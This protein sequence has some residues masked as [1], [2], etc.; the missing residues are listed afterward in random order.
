MAKATDLQIK[1]VTCA[2]EPIAFRTPLKFG[3][4]VQKTA[5]LVNVDV[6]VESRDGKHKGQ[7][8]GSMPLGNLWSWPSTVCTPDQTEAAMKLF[9]EEIVNLAQICT[10]AGHPIDLVYHLAGEYPHLAKTLAV[11]NKMPE[12]LPALAQLVAASALDAALHDAFGRM[13]Q[14]SS[15]DVLTK[16][17]MTFDLSEYLDKSF[18]GEYLDRYTLRIPAE[19]LA[20][21]HLVGAVDPL[22]AG[23]VAQKI[24]DGLPEY[25]GE[26]IVRDQLTHLKIKLRGNDP[27]WDRARILG[28]D[29]VATTTAQQTQWHYSLD[30]NEQCES[31]DVVLSLLNFL[32]TD[33][34]AIYERIE[35]IEQ[36]THRDLA[37]HAISMHEVAKLKPVVI[38]ESLVDYDA[39]VAARDLGYS[40]VAI[41]A[42][43]GQ[44]ESLLL[45]AAAQKFGMFLCVQDLTCPGASFLHSASLAAH[46]PGIKAV[47]GNGRQYCPAA[48]KI[49]ARDYPE[50]FTVKHGVI[51]TAAM[52]GPGLGF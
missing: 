11:R 28:V 33:H 37:A 2:F 1:D 41:K 12:A 47:E 21:Y 16:K 13:H 35:Y 43:K 51:Q 48:N 10:E 5:V 49:W 15:Y 29:Q 45:A 18:A 50:V 24:G 14:M 38:D 20:L 42:C 19:T 30:F 9:V 39:L 31:A 3:D 27:G 34:P 26:W 32:K 7:G 40:G 4:R 36:P 44:T 25:L 17:Y 6:V 22:T 23:D 8:Y 46:L 52:N